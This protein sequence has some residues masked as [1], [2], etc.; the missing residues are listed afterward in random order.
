MI[1]D[2][3]AGFSKGSSIQLPTAQPSNGHERRLVELCTLPVP[4]AIATLKTTLEG[5]TAKEA[6]HRL[7]EFGPNELSHLKRLGFWADMVH[8]LRSP[9]VI[10]L[11]VIA[12]VSAVTGELKSAL[13][14]GGMIL[15]SVGLSY[16]LDRRSSR[17][18]ESLGKR[19]QSRAFT[20]RDGVETEVRISE[21]VPGD[22]VLLQAG[23]IVPADLRLITAKDFFVS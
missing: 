3:F 6:E 7:G 22:I 15:L 19:V 1:K 16:I 21:I 10:Q 23:S 17:A 12:L 5:L 11:L 2:F 13:I 20:L 18:V 4:E 14:V 8:R 9:L